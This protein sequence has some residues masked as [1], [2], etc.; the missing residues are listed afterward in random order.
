MISDSKYKKPNYK[1]SAGFTIFELIVVIIIVSILLTILI[2]D[3]S[4]AKLQFSLSR[5]AYKFS[6]DVSRAQNLAVSAVPYKDSFGTEQKVD[7]YGIYANLNSLGNKKYL[8]YA[9]KNP[10]NQQYDS[11]DYIIETIDFSL[12]EPGIII[13]E[14]NNVT[15]NQASVNFNSADLTTAITQLNSGQNS[16]I[17]VFALVSDLTKT[18]SVVINTSGLAESSPPPAAPPPLSE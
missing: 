18:K 4:K 16:A 11:S 14:I 12:T 10:G 6:Q 15:N 8:I 17:F 2:S 1:D 5:V 9:D 7:G 13:K 3:F